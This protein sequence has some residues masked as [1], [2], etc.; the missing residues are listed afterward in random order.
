MSQCRLP[1][2]VDLPPGMVLLLPGMEQVTAAMPEALRPMAEAARPLAHAAGPLRQVL[3]NWLQ[4]VHGP[5]KGKLR[6]TPATTSREL[7]QNSKEESAVTDRF[8]LSS[9]LVRDGTLKGPFLFKGKRSVA[10]RIQELARLEQEILAAMEDVRQEYEGQAIPGLALQIWGRKRERVAPAK[11]EERNPSHLVWRVARP[12]QANARVSWKRA[13]DLG[14]LE[15]A[16][17]YQR[18][19]IESLGQRCM[20]L[21]AAIDVVTAERRVLTELLVDLEQCFPGSERE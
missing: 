8:P 16:S 13:L 18:R 3:D 15:L 7:R 19:N 6:Q 21:N 14:A 5:I 9:A 11:R 10:L 20:Q 4:Q 2:T 1:N 17:G 12:G